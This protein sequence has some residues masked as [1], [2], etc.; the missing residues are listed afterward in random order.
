[1]TTPKVLTTP[2]MYQ[3]VIYQS[4]ASAQASQMRDK[5][6]T[7]TGQ[8]LLSDDSRYAIPGYSADLKYEYGGLFV[9]PDP[10]TGQ[11]DIPDE[12]KDIIGV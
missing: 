5:P 12:F 2:V 8:T 7:T 3:G 4:S 6:L 10:A 11:T 1:M 9:N